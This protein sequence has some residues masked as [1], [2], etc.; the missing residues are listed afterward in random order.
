MYYFD[1]LDRTTYPTYL[2]DEIRHLRMVEVYF[3]RAMIPSGDMELLH[4]VLN[5]FHE[6]FNKE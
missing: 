6:M 3:T 5:Q 1:V 2:V 4:Y